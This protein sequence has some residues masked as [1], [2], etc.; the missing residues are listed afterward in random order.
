MM[1][2]IIEKEGKLDDNLRAFTD[3]A[4]KGKNTYQTR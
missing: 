3:L 4:S 2:F 1:P